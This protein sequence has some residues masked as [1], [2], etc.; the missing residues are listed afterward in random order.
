MFFCL[1]VVLA[2]LGTP[3][4]YGQVAENSA[5]CAE[6]AEWLRQINIQGDEWSTVFADKSHVLG[7]EAPILTSEFGYSDVL[8]VQ[9]AV[10]DKRFEF[11]EV[12]VDHCS[13]SVSI[14]K[15]Y[16]DVHEVYAYK[17]HERIFAYK[18][19]GETVVLS[20][21][22]WMPCMCTISMTIYDS[23]GNGKFDF[24]RIGMG[25]PPMIPGWAK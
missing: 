15:S 20:K 18:L 2:S 3:L 13:H 5:G 6:K 17:K 19:T 14:K 12:I 21:G 24:L 4:L 9:Y 8:E 1:A 25:G 11:P 23:T 7:R 22:E 10:R 16:L